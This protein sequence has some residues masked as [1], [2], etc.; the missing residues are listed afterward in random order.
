MKGTRRFP[1]CCA[2]TV[3]KSA[4]RRRRAARSRRA[5]P[6]IRGAPEARA[7]TRPF[8]CAI[9]LRS[10]RPKRRRCDNKQGNAPMDAAE[11]QA[12]RWNST[13]GCAWVAAQALLD[14]LFKPLEALLVDAA[15]SQSPQE[16]LDVGC[17]T[18]G[19]TVAI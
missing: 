17:G 7:V 5:H 15:A 10:G 1:T 2:D 13:A 8:S 14:R 9:G 3:T 19:T 16:V 18:G 12:K 6:A 4:R 11:D